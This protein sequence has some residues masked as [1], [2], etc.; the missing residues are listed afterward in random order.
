MTPLQLLATAKLAEGEGIS[1]HNIASAMTGYFQAVSDLN[2]SLPNFPVLDAS[3][4]VEDTTIEGGISIPG[5]DKSN[6]AEAISAYSATLINGDVTQILTPSS[7]TVPG[8]FEALIQNI[9]NCTEAIEPV[10]QFSVLKDIIENKTFSDFG[11]S[12]SDYTDMASMGISKTC[13]NIADTIRA[14]L[15]GPLPSISHL[16]DTD[17]AKIGNIVSAQGTV[18]GDFKSVH[19]GTP[20]G[21][22]DSAVLAGNSVANII[23]KSLLEN[24]GISLNMTIPGVDYEYFSYLVKS[25]WDDSSILHYFKQARFTGDTL[26]KSDLKTERVVGSKIIKWVVNREE[27]G[28]DAFRQRIFSHFNEALSNP[29]SYSNKPL[30]KEFFRTSIESNDAIKTAVDELSKDDARILFTKLGSTIDVKKLRFNS[31][32]LDIARCAGAMPSPMTD[33]NANTAMKSTAVPPILSDTGVYNLQPLPSEGSLSNDE[34]N[35]V[36]ETLSDEE[37]AIAHVKSLKKE[38]LE[39]SVYTLLD[40][41][42]A[43]SNIKGFDNTIGIKKLAN[44]LRSMEETPTS[45]SNLSKLQS[46]FPSELSENMFTNVFNVSANTNILDFLGSAAGLNDQVSIWNRITTLL[47]LLKEKVSFDS[48]TQEL[49]DAQTLYDESISL[50]KSEYYLLHNV[51]NYDPDQTVIVTN[52]S[53]MQWMTTVTEFVKSFDIRGSLVKNF[54]DPTTLGGEALLSSMVETR[55]IQKLQ[56]IGFSPVN[57]IEY[58]SANLTVLE[59]D[60]SKASKINALMNDASSITPSEIAE[61]RITNI[62]E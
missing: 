4:R 40:F 14:Y 20:R 11:P 6:I 46:L 25:N 43:L 58:N 24:V 29:E 9:R 49:I 33:K 55:N 56:R 8:N 51:A 30:Y 60:V 21:I 2:S 7:L 47:N 1:N 3:I 61:L 57:N 18:S 48:N 15:G 41:K 44:V 19:F 26:L 59:E 17:T 45:N 23:R 22:Y 42:K 53:I 39:S 16:P 62:E 31:D 36:T 38:S 12:A 13:S 34:L 35:F 10:K 27:E 37:K 50:I 54:A 28:V 5:F 52:R 32:I